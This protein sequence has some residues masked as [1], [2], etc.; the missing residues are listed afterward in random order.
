MRLII[1]VVMP[2]VR[3]YS[4]ED[5]TNL[6]KSLGILLTF[7]GSGAVLKQ[8]IAQGEVISKGTSV[9]LTLSSDYKD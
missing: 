6:L 9:K 2:N 8:D 1:N 5:A 4:K 3:G 7:E